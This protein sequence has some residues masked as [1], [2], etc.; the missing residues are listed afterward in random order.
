MQQGKISKFIRRFQLLQDPRIRRVAFYKIL[1]RA[2]KL[3]LR[4]LSLFRKLSYKVIYKFA[5]YKIRQRL[6]AI[7]PFLLVKNSYVRQYLKPDLSIEEF[8]GI[9]NERGVQYV[10]LRWF[11]AFP[12]I[13]EGEDIDLLVCDEDV[14]RIMD[15]FGGNRDAQAFDIYN[16]TGAKGHD[17]KS[18]PYYPPNVAQSILDNRLFKDELYAIPNPK[19]H[20]LSMAYHVV[21]HKGSAAGL[22]SAEPCDHDYQMV[23]NDIAEAA[24]EV[25]DTSNL[26]G[27]YGYLDENKWVPP[28]DTLGHL[29][30]NNV[31]L[32][33][34]LPEPEPVND[35]G[36]LVLF[37]VR[38]WGV[39]HKKIDDIRRKITESGLEVIENLRLN[40]VQREA[41]QAYIRGGKWDKGPYP[42]S[43]GCPAE[44]LFCFDYHPRIPSE[45]TRNKYPFLVNAN[46][47]I[48][49]TVRDYLNNEMV[50]FKHSNC[51]H[52]ADSE[53]EAWEYINAVVPEAKPRIEAAIDERRKEYSGEYPVLHLYDSNRTRAKIEKIEYKGGVAVKKTFKVGYERF[54][55][56]E[57]FA[58]EN[59]SKVLD[60]VPPLL[61]RGEN[62]CIIPWYE[63]TFG[64]LSDE[65]KRQ[66]LRPYGQKIMD[67]IKYIYD[68]GYA[69]IGAYVGN[70]IVT[71]DG[72]LIIID[73]EFLHQY[74]DKPD[75]FRQAYDIAG[76]PAGYKDD[77]PIGIRGKGHTYKNTWQY[78]LGPLEQYI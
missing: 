50:L 5:P 40:A 42:V 27:I 63:D 13:E 26:D 66:V 51:I 32:R 2:I 64:S 24:G 65:H 69:L 6:F 36:E 54:L 57:V 10:V 4:G 45:K 68:Q 78:Y 41:A 31:W 37:I 8:F 70:I 11:E 71:P 73:Y 43:G 76:L 28:L 22:S 72:R 1:N 7:F 16:L 56:K 12:F 77:L 18:L 48:K 67:T 14:D 19:H 30:K 44:F 23:L 33:S 59:F 61:E 20:L 25:L 53:K 9:M 29:S 34:K 39:E 49:H 21:F 38:D 3:S 17:Y 60:T 15:L 46:I 55:E 75:N 47:S 35:K 58:Y 74:E 62:Y 52:S